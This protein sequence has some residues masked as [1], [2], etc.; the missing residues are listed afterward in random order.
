MTLGQRV[1]KSRLATWFFTLAL[2]VIAALCGASAG[3][4]L[5][6]VVV[7]IVVGTWIGLRACFEMGV[8]LAPAE[9]EA[10]VRGEAR[11]VFEE[12]RAQ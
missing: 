2:A 7:G 6:G 11:K 1:F 5:A 9:A 8:G 12:R 3:S 10:I 4:Y